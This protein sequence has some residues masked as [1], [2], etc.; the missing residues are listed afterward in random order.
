MTNKNEDSYPAVMCE[1]GWDESFLVGT[2]EELRSFANKILE[3]I[4][5]PR[6]KRDF[7]GAE[8]SEVS[9]RISELWGDACIDGI[10][11]TSNR[12]DTKKLINAI[13]INNGEDP[14]AAEGWP[15]DHS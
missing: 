5:K 6:D 10:I 4:D 12:P 3:E 14:I 15:V 2:K 7:F 1:T 8:A 9:E 13:R 11:I